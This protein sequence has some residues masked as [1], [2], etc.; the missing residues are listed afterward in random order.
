M[1]ASHLHIPA[2]RGADGLRRAVAG[3]FGTENVPNV[4]AQNPRQESP[5]APGTRARGLHPPLASAG[6]TRGLRSQA[7][8]DSVGQTL[9]GSGEW[10]KPDAPKPRLD[11]NL[12]A[13]A[14]AM[15]E[16]S[17]ERPMTARSN[18]NKS[19]IEG[20]IFGSGPADAARPVLRNRNASSV[21]GG[22]FG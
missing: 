13:A 5:P 20:G 7:V 8:K 15:K 18:P 14:G 6:P 22:I 3:I 10:S 12:Q 11:P 1:R 16:A 4:P 21:A 19:S 9:F 17:P 2:P